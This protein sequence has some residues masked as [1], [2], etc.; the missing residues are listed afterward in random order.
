ME[1]SLSGCCCDRHPERG[2]Q[3]TGKVIAGRKRPV[4][5]RHYWNDVSKRQCHWLCGIQR[6][7][8]VRFVPIVLLDCA[9]PNKGSLFG[10]IPI[11]DVEKSWKFDQV[12]KSGRNSWCCWHLRGHG[13]ATFFFIP[14]CPLER[15]ASSRGRCFFHSSLSRAFSKASN[16]SGRGISPSSYVLFVLFCS[17]SWAVYGQANPPAF[18]YII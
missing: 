14:L 5:R 13:I 2:A 8:E 4:H 3:E 17:R 10:F 12:E 18:S 6:M 7:D 1:Q 15:L 11:L 9:K 16:T